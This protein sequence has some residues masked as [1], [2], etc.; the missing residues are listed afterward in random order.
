MNKSIDID[1]WKFL[2]NRLDDNQKKVLLQKEN[3]RIGNMQSHLIS[4]P[5]QWN[6]LLKIS[7]SNLTNKNIQK[8]IVQ[9]YLEN[10][11]N[12]NSDIENQEDHLKNLDILEQKDIS[13]S[14]EEYGFFYVLI[15]LISKGYSEKVNML[16]EFKPKE[17]VNITESDTE[18][19]SEFESNS[20]ELQNALQEII[21]LKNELSSMNKTNKSLKKKYDLLEAKFN[22]YKNQ[23]RKEITIL[24]VKF[25]NYKNQKNKEIAILEEKQNSDIEEIFNNWDN[26]KQ[27]YESKLKVLED[28]NQ[29]L[30]KQLNELYNSQRN[31]EQE[32][33]NEIVEKSTLKKR[34]SKVLVFGKLPLN[35]QKDENYT[36]VLFNHDISN[37]LFNEKYDEYWLIED[38]LS[39][40]EKKQLKNNINSSK[41]NLFK[42][43]YNDLIR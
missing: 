13:S 2:F 1:V 27:K 16:I 43:N 3:I 38:K 25:N 40:K 19:E 26:D 32:F 7:S 24:E 39:A 21:N 23:E 8:A 22:D 14:I 34:Q 35:I 10:I 5:S 12:L 11:P 6:V 36:F 31:Q 20:V 17:T 4:K 9:Y 18:S 15:Y 41:I 33:K 30:K 29:I 28:E 42:K 37:Y